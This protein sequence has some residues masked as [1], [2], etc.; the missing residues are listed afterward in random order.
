ML[1][2]SEQL[3][4]SGVMMHLLSINQLNQQTLQHLLD[5]AQYFLDHFV[6]QQK[7]SSL[8]SGKVMVNLFFEP[9]TRT[10]FSF[11]IAGHRLGAFVLNPITDRI[12]TA[13]GESLLDTVKSFIAI[14]SRLIVIRHRENHTPEWLANEIGN[15]ASII[16]GG[17]GVN[18]HPTQA[19]L[20][21]LTIRQYKPSFSKITVAIIGDIAH[22]R[23]ARSLVQGLNILDCTNIR[24]IAPPEFLPSDI[25]AWPVTTYSDLKTGLADADVI[26]TLRIQLERITL[27]PSVSEPA[28]FFEKFRLTTEHLRFADPH[29]IVMHPA[30]INRE[31][32]I[33]SEVVDGSQS[34]IF[35]QI[36][37]GVA[38]RM[39]V[40]EWCSL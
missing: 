10:Q 38:V 34:V 2:N 14:G 22:S 5:R 23:V 16:N 17:D 8:M 26:V 15:Q 28:K 30:P 33:T 39:A 11:T 24:V 18:Q 37:N 32:E 6:K 31:T 21:L 35:Q 1:E 40:I 25:E 29:A 3:S 12:S 19:I 20:D 9:S 4:Y 27:P 7:Q 36:T 13:K